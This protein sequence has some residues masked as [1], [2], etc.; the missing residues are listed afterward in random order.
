MTYTNNQTE[1]ISKNFTQELTIAT[2]KELNQS[3][4]SNISIEPSSKYNMIQSQNEYKN[5][6]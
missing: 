1:K 6:L 4:K 2:S 3:T 5:E